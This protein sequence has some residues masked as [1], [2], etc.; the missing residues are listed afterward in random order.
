[1][2]H[3]LKLKSSRHVLNYHNTHTW[4]V[5]AK[6][7]QYSYKLLKLITNTMLLSQVTSKM[8]SR[9]LK[10]SQVDTMKSLIT[11]VP[12]MLQTLS[13]SWVQ[14]VLLYKKQSIT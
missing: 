1:M 5:V 2:F 3:G 9:L 13:L 4:L 10:R 14:V 8:L 12:K 6:V 7:H 11:M